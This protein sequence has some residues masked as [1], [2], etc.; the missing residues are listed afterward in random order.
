MEEK[1]PHVEFTAEME[2]VDHLIRGIPIVMMTFINDN[3]KLCS[4]PLLNQDLEFDGSLWFLI[5]KSSAKFQDLQKHN[6]VSLSY[7]DK[8]KCVSINGIVE[9]TENRDMVRELWQKPHEAWFPDGP[10]DPTIQ[11][12]KVH[13]QT[14]EYWEGHTSPIYKMIDFVKGALGRPTNKESHSSFD[15]KH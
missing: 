10:Q 3:N 5:S 6:D 13:V 4:F 1:E 12:L 14:V 7:S 15:L 2:K 8:N 11:L 9:F